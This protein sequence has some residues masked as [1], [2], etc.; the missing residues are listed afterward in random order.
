[1]KVLLTHLGILD[2]GRYVNDT[3]ALTC[4][5]AGILLVALPFLLAAIIE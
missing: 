4:I 2:G 3:F 5:L 1:M